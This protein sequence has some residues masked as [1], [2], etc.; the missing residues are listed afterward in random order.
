MEEKQMVGERTEQK[1]L[2]SKTS[3]KECLMRGV[4][5]IDSEIYINPL[6]TTSMH[7]GFINSNLFNPFDECF[8]EKYTREESYGLSEV[9]KPFRF[10]HGHLTEI[11]NKRNSC[12]SS[13]ET[14]NNAGTQKTRASCSFRSYLSQ[15]LKGG[16][17]GCIG[18]GKRQAR[19]RTSGN[20]L[21][22]TQQRKGIELRLKEL[23][24]ASYKNTCLGSPA[25][26]LGVSIR[27]VPL[28]SRIAFL[29]RAQA[30]KRNI[31]RR[32]S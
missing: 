21:R 24:S 3:V 6:D 15:R 28:Y 25:D 17:L 13:Q 11:R 32:L 2:N 10:S 14:R 1:D 4:Q 8:S 7:A 29:N 12:S 9:F 27:G 5:S 20:S 31:L 16:H 26:S 30:Y 19:D 18:F 22:D 23:S